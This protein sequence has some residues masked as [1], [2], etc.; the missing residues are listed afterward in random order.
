MTRITLTLVVLLSPVL[1][2]AQDDTYFTFGKVTY[3]EIDKKTYPADTSA[4]AYVI[5]ELAEAHV[6][7]ETN[8][9]LIFTYHVKVKVLK[10]AGARLGDIL[11]LLRK[12]AG[13]AKEEIRAVQA[14]A[15]NLVNNKIEET[16]MEYSAVFVERNGKKRHDEAKFVIPNVRAGTIIEYKYEIESPFLYNFRKWEFQTDIPKMHSEYWTIIPGNYVYNITLRG[17]LKITETKE[18]VIQKC[19]TSGGGASAA[20]ASTRYIM[21]DI[22]AFKEEE[23]MTAKENY[24]SSI[25]FEL[26]EVRH[27]DGRINKITKEWKD[28]DEELRQDEKFGQQLR[29]NRDTFEDRLV[30]SILSD[31]DPLSKAKKVYDHVKFA[32]VWNDYYGAYT[33]VGIKKALEEKKGNVADINLALVAAL[34]YAGFD[35]D[36]VMLAT[37]HIERPIEIHPVLNDFN[38]VIA[39]L[40]LGD[41]VYLLDAVDDYL[42]FGTIS[43]FCYNGN[44]RVISEK[45]SYW[46]EIK[47]TDRDRIVT[48]IILKLS[49]EGMMNGTITYTYYGYANVDQRKTM[50]GFTDEKAYLDEVKSNSHDMG[51]ASYTRTMDDDVSKPVVEIFT[52]EIPAFDSPATSHFLFNPFFTRRLESNPFKTETRNFPVDYGVPIDRNLIVTIEYPDNIEVTSLPD[53]IGVALPNAGGKYI[54]AA[55]ADGTKL[56]INNLLSITKPMYSPEE[57]PY[58]RELYARRIQAENADI[59]FQKKK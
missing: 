39:K 28:A 22:P 52:V 9:K 37:R 20:C 16:K 49:K 15:F 42:P 43:E 11:V 12:G 36:P 13:S 8:N 35:A 23:H 31:A 46:M 48:L 55:Q 19:V 58:L 50:L 10:Q 18:D 6:D 41:K 3:A 17:Y 38:Y 57:Y 44:G 26:S 45:G 7:Y 54:Y 27:W 47:P 32:M 21:K 24:M 5:K 40:T 56:V 33:D 30:A 29:K 59:I 14:S 51:I 2:L 34:R 1:A 53:K 4:E 25:N